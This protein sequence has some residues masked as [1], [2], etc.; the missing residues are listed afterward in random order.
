MAAGVYFAPDA[1]A[2]YTA[3]GFQAGPSLAS[4]EGIQRPELRS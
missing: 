3:L 4:K 2:E 1:H